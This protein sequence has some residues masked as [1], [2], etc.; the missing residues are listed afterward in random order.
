[1]AGLDGIENQTEPGEPINKNITDLTKREIKRI[2]KLPA[3]LEDALAALETDYD[4]LLRG[5][6]L[7]ETL[8]NNWT[9][10]KRYTEIERL[11]YRPHPYEYNMYFDL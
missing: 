5:G 6:I 9:K 11:Q 8:I 4:Y 1:M 7:D 2:K 10:I 3:S